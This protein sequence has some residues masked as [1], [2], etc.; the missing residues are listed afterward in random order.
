[1]EPIGATA[2]TASRW[3]SP[4]GAKSRGTTGANR[5]F[6]PAAAAGG[7]EINRPYELRHS[8]ASLWLRE[9]INPVQVAQ[10]LGHNPGMTFTTYAHVIA[11]LDPKDRTPAERMITKA[12]R[13]VT[14]L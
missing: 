6:G 5:K 4:A 2:S 13:A 7:V 10:W 9:G 14:H 1:M 3:C 11:D 8:I 12:R